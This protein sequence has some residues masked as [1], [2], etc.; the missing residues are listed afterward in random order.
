MRTGFFLGCPGYG[1]RA[2]LLVEDAMLP[3][4]LTPPSR[5]IIVPWRIEGLDSAPCTVLAEY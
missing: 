3:A 1:D 2:V 5:I 4:D